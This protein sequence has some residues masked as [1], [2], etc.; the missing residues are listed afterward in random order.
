MKITFIRP[1]MTADRSSDAMPPLAFAAL[2]AQTPEGATIELYDECIE[3]IPEAIETDM[4]GL[5][6]HT[7]SSRRA[8]ELADRYRM[9]GIPVVMGGYHPTF[10]PDEAL[11][12]AD[13]V[14]TG[15]AE[16]LWQEVVRDAGANRLHRL[17]RSEVSPAGK[18]LKYDMT[19]FNGKNYGP[20]SLVEFTRGCRYS[21]EFCSINTFNQ[22]THTTRPFQAVVEDIENSGARKVLFL[23]DNFFSDKEEAWRLVE[24]LIPL[25]I[26][27]GCQISI[28]IA[29]DREMLE[30]M[31]ESGCVLLMIGFE[32]LRGEN[33]KQMRKGSHGSGTT[34]EEAIGQIKERGIMVYGSFVF[35]Y[36]HDTLDVFEETLDFAMKNKFIA[37]NFNTLNPLP[38]TRLY[39]RLKAEGRLK[40][41]QWWLDEKYKYGEVMF[42]PRRMTP[43]QLKEGCIRI[44][45]AFSSLPAILRRGLDFRANCRNR[46]NLGLFLLANLVTRREYKRKMKLI[47]D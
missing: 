24:A 32:S 11:S 20:L 37:T 26:R 6:V 36:D 41:E 42:E 1:N 9:K 12:H 43:R 2:A 3:E 15:P 25:K 40:A 33:L 30:L 17:Y 46:T 31:A 45:F 39:H 35:G 27:W 29:G 23:D 13:A 38:G 5:T 22:N 28:D 44:R 8:Y 34:F 18:D 19:V 10:L 21:C 14:V 7:F 16:G 4:I 47:Q